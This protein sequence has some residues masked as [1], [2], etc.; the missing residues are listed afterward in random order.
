MD[1]VDGQ[2]AQAPAV[3]SAAA[4]DDAS[5]APTNGTGKTSAAWNTPKHREEVDAY[6]ARL[7]DQGFNPGRN[8]V[9]DALSCV[10]VCVCVCLYR[11]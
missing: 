9:L 5:A 3:S 11:R 4:G 7:S 6:R 10:C 8:P 2:S 1:I